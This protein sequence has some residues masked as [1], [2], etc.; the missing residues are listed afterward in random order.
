MTPQATLVTAIN[1]IPYGYFYDIESP[2]RGRPMQSVD[3][4]GALWRMLP[5]R[6][7]LGAVVY[8]AAEVVSLG[9]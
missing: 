1:G 5:P 2:W 8:P 4:G 3:P 6:Q 7:V 9:S